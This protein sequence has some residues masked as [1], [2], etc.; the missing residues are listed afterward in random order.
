[1]TNA[2]G[3]PDDPRLSFDPDHFTCLGDR[4]DSMEDEL[5]G[6]Y[7]SWEDLSQRLAA[8]ESERLE[9]ARLLGMSASSEASLL[10]HLERARRLIEK[11][12]D[13]L[14]KKAY[15]DHGHYC[16]SRKCVM[17]AAQMIDAYEKANP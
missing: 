2:E 11:V 12:N 13:A 9:Q 7:K 1:M 10:G 8:S 6:L 17:A 15:R 3:I 14:G 4:I 16:E 5:A